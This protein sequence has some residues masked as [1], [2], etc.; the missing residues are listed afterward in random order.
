MGYDLF[1]YFIGPSVR[2]LL[3]NRKKRGKAKISESN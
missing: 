3:L 2:E 1:I